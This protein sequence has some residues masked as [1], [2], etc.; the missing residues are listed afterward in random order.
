MDGEYV[1]EFTTIAEAYYKTG[2]LDFEISQCCRGIKK[3]VDGFKWVYRKDYYNENI[4]I[5]IK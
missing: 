3:E 4:G 1:D 2:S 5:S